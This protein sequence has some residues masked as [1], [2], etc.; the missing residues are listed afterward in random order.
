M[1]SKKRGEGKGRKTVNKRYRKIERKK[2][3]RA[4]NER[5]EKYRKPKVREN[6]SDRSKSMHR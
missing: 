2:E 4:N 5:K 3:N 6:T 1:L